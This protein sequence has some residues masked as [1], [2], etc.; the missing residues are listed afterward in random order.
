M[1]R[2]SSSAIDLTT[3]VRRVGTTTNPAA[4][5]NGVPPQGVLG[6]S[7]QLGD[8]GFLTNVHPIYRAWRNIWARNER[9]LAG[10][11]EVVVELQPFQWEDLT[12][13]HYVYRQSMAT[14]VHFPEEF[15]IM[16]T[17]HLM[18]QAPRPQRE[19]NFGTLGEVRTLQ[20]LAG[21]LTNAELVYYGADG[22]GNDGTQWD[23]FW[24]GASRRA[25]A[26]GHRWIMV[27]SAMG[28]ASSRQDI[29]D[30]KRPYLQ[31]W[32]PLDVY[33]WHFD[34]G[35][36]QYAIIRT[37]E[38]DPRVE[39]G[40]FVTSSQQEQ[41][42]YLLVKRGFEGLGAEFVGG[43]WWKFDPD[44]KPLESNTF[45]MTDGQIPMFPLYYQRDARP[46]R[47][48]I[49]LT[50][51][52]GAITP[53][54]LAI[55][56]AALTLQSP[57]MSRPGTSELGNVAVSYMNLASAADFDA[58]DAGSSLT[59]LLGCDKEGYNLAKSKMDDGSRLI[60]VPTNQESG[61]APQ[62]MDS[63]TGAIVSAVFTAR[64]QAKMDEAKILAAREI[65]SV[66]DSSGESK[67][68]GF[69]EVKAPRLA[70]MASEVEQAQNA[71]IW[72]L[73][74]R[75]GNEKPTGGVVW[76]R[77]FSL[78]GLHEQVDALFARE[79]ASG[80]KSPTLGAKAMVAAAEEDGLIENEAEKTTVEAEYK[81]SAG[82]A[83][84]AAQK[85]LEAPVAPNGA[86]DGGNS[87]TGGGQG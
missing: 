75:F 44:M 50:G 73:E 60:P 33:D 7:G 42:Y 23:N 22:V 45:D 64:L 34:R 72:F 69:G 30:G 48:L 10:G 47:K 49:Q 27:E 3:V 78:E 29:L 70:L 71:A 35:Q 38:R 58:W 6:S 11:D 46:A 56:G 40:A 24:A 1:A 52:P 66:P 36:L 15:A 68:A 37:N 12:D 87:Q 21:D 53:P 65:A 41:S 13:D 51:D 19:L 16:M 8:Y 39:N 17:G 74:K 61:Q 84:K 59:F 4:M 2:R 14:Y 32:S 67:K 57:A 86:N 82:D 28:G 5:K 63:G 31:E 76:T 20:E 18:R 77:E 83:Q 25:M 85:A 54:P 79:T 81:Q 26:T 80:Y 55:G 9:R 43:G 62:V